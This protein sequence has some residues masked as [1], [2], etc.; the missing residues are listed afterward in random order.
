MKFIKLKTVLSDLA[1]TL[2]PTYWNE[3]DA[4]EWAFKAMRKIR[5]FEQYELWMNYA[6]VADYKADL[7]S[8]LDK[9]VLVAY[10]FDGNTVTDLEE[11]QQDL[12]VDND[13]YYTG[14]TESGLFFSNYRPLRLERSPFSNQVLCEECENLATHS[15][16]SYRINPN[17]T[18]TTSFSTGSVCYAYLRFPVDCDGD[19]LIPDLED[20]IDAVR[21]YILSRFWEMRWNANEPGADAKFDHYSI[22]WQTLCRKVKGILKGFTNIDVLEN[23]R[24]MINRL[25]PRERDYYTGFSNRRE[26]N[27]EF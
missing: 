16:H 5:A 24:Q 7:P 14:F 8:D 26:E 22:R 27:L 21:S 20:Y 9:L 18:I 1:S 17:M 6:V 4:V 3:A 2:D 12:G 10:K 23:I 15:E 11:I 25:V 13:N 19:Y